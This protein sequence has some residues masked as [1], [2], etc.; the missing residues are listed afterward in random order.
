MPRFDSAHSF[1][2]FCAYFQ[3]AEAFFEIQCDWETYPPPIDVALR[4]ALL[5]RIR[6]N[7]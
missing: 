1:F 5:N 7:A 2:I 3:N 6:R 4:Y